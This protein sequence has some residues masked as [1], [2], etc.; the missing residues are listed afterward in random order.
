MGAGQATDDSGPVA[1][2]AADGSGGNPTG[3]PGAGQAIAAGLVGRGGAG[4]QRL[5][6]AGPSGGG[7]R[8]RGAGPPGGGAAGEPVDGGPAPRG[9]GPGPS[10][11][12]ATEPEAMAARSG[13]QAAEAPGL[14]PGG[15]L[16]GDDDDEHHR[17]YPLVVDADEVFAGGLPKMAPEALGESPQ[18]RAVRHARE[19][20][21]GH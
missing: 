12:A 14:V 13:E 2:P 19:A 15:G 17:K 8:L 7:Q 18:Q 4:G 10:G 16:P 11:G 20:E 3:V 1:E 9:A 6:G 5:P 21:G